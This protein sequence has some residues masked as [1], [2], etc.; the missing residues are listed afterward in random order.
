MIDSL[1]NFSDF[2]S[3]ALAGLLGAVIGI[4]REVADKPAGFRTHVL[5]AAGSA[6]LVVLAQSSLADFLQ[7]FPREGQI[8]TDPVRV[9]QAI[10]VGITFLGAGTIV[11]R[12]GDEVEGLTTAASIFL[13]AGLGIAVAVG[14]PWLAVQTTLFALILLIVGHWIEVRLPKIKKKQ[15]TD[16]ASGGR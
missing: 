7:R 3:V 15:S 16:Q 11:H 10:V 12:G 5:V 1:F 8:R 13:T 9:I 6:L 4:E 14:R 2:G